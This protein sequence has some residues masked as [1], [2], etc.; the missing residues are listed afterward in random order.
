MRLVCISFIELRF[1]TKI[2]IYETRST[3]LLDYTTLSG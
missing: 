3:H 1:I 2:Y